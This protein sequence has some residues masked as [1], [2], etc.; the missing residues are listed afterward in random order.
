M[1]HSPVFSALRPAL[2]RWLLLLPL[3]LSTMQPAS[4][5]G[6]NEDDPLPPEEA[7]RF[8]A[9][10]IDTDTLRA[11]WTIAEGHYLY[12]SKL[13][14]ESATPGVALGTPKIPDGTLK[15]DEFF[16][17]QK[18]HRGTLHID[19]PLFNRANSN[20]LRLIAQ[21]QGCADRG[22]C[23]PP[24]HTEVTLTLAAAANSKPTAADLLGETSNTPKGIK[25]RIKGGIKGLVGLD[26]D[27]PLPPEEA[28]RFSA[29]EFEN[30][31]IPLRW[32]IAEDHY[33]Y[34]DKFVFRLLESEG[35]QLGTPAIPAGKKKSDPLFGEIEAHYT[36]VA[37]DLPLIGAGRAKIEATWQG[38]AERGICYPPQKRVLEVSGTGLSAD[39]ATPIPAATRANPANAAEQDRIA[40]SLAHDGMA[41]ALL[42]FFVFGL[43]LAFT[44]CVFP[45]IPI[46]SGIIIGHGE[47]LTARRGL[48]LSAIYVLAMALTYS[49]A[50]VLAG[51]FGQNLQAAFQN[52]WVLT[53]F[54]AVFVALAFS[55]FGFYELQLPSGLQSRV[56][57]LS[58]KQHGGSTTGVA[59]MGLLS[60]LIVGP[61]VAPP[62]AGALIY[63]GQTGDAV[64]GGLALFVMALGMGAP[65][66][67]IGASA[68]RILPRAGGWMDAVKAVF[69]VLMLAVAIWLLERVLPGSVILLLWSALLIIS[70]IYMGA[71]ERIAEGASGWRKLWK[72]LGILLLSWGVLM[73]L[74]VAAGKSDPLAPL[75]G[76]GIG[77]GG[78][79]GAETHLVFRSIKG[80]EGLDQAL[81]QAK[82]ARQPVMLDFYADW[83]ISCKELEKY[84]FSDKAVQTALTGTLLL[85]ADVTAND[86]EDQALLKKLGLIGPPAIL[87]FDRD[88]N[89]LRNARLVGFLPPEEFAPHVRGA[90]Q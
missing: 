72:G 63:I 17:E 69:G 56:A 74:G 18:V 2:Q 28:F 48:Y 57:T 51:L 50:G 14:F 16:G 73:L 9:E 15:N 38:C 47:R 43:L 54:A 86:A 4:A 24:Y 80:V 10:A 71:L 68:G 55:M 49:V 62:L 30:G 84:T 7:F 53:T 36:S 26:S 22:I 59:V 37:F 64:L 42:T 44:P 60:A 11:T 19:I 21:G 25:D 75:A 35:L 27:E 8:S 20:R 58:N 76:L 67:L 79:S 6:N 34:H 89:E 5:Q 52:P 3:L 41:L 90:L 81:A 83:C 46:L 77:S 70:A 87:F 85:Q 32:E 13:R 12:D 40:D 31:V 66:L 23:Y 29:G 45:M 39:N 65:L 1:T 82:T 61:C 33:L 78:E 88:G